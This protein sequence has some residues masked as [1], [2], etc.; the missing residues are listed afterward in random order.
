MRS[1]AYRNIGKT[2]L[3]DK[4][5][6]SQEE[7]IRNTCNGTMLADLDWPLNASRGFV[8]ISW[9]SCLLPT[10]CRKAANCRYYFYWPKVSI[11]APQGR[12]SLHRFTWNLAWPRGTSVRLAER[13]FTSIGGRGWVRGSEEVENFHFLL[14]IRPAGANQFQKTFG[15]FMRRT[16]LRKCFKF[17]MICFTDYG[18]ITEKLRV[19]HLPRSFLCIL[20]EKLCVG[21]KNDCHISEW[22]RRPLPPCKV[23][24]DRTT[25]AGCR[26]ENMVFVCVL[27]VCHAPRPG[28]LF[29]PGAYFEQVLCY[30]LLVH[31]DAVLAA[32]FERYCHFRWTTDSQFLSP[33]GAIIF[34]KLRS[35]TVRKWLKKNNSHLITVQ[36]WI[37]WNYH[38]WGATPAAILKPSP[39]AHNFR[40]KRRI[41][42]YGPFS[43][44]LINKPVPSFRN[45]LIENV[46]VISLFNKCSH[47][48]CLRWLQ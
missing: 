47:F 46:K 9:A 14:K 20:H 36:I 40:I 3:K 38:I 21:S 31:F 7:T 23:W 4:V 48:W 19:G 26:C 13:N 17:D 18:V 33:G 35:K 29:V 43:A 39:E 27:F 5:T 11:F 8:S 1:I 25:R 24:R 12:D 44:G 28:A 22:S 10:G 37:Q 6:N 45:S 34:A 30:G 2:R 42:R 41:R 15:A 32:F 16:A